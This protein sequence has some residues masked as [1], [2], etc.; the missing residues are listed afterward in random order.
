MYVASDHG[1][2]SCRQYDYERIRR[3]YDCNSLTRAGTRS[4]T[5]LSPDAT[6]SHSGG[7]VPNGEVAVTVLGRRDHWRYKSMSTPRP[8]RPT[9]LPSYALDNSLLQL[10]H[11]PASQTK[12]LSSVLHP[13]ATWLSLRMLLSRVLGGISLPRAG[14]CNR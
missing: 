7:Y 8:P 6:T 3:F 12:E 5:D 2:Y 9:A 13:R 14:R 1:C 11:R 4:Q 10:V